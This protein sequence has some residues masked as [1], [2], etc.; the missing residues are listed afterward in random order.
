LVERSFQ[1]LEKI[2]IGESGSICLALIL[3]WRS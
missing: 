3:L 2:G 1:V